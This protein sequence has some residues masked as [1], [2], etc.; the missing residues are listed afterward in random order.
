MIGSTSL[1]DVEYLP[2]DQP[3]DALADVGRLL[4]LVRS[5]VADARFARSAQLTMTEWSAFFAGMVNAYLAADS[6]AGRAGLVAVP[7]ENRAIAE[8]R[9][10]PAARSATG[11]HVKAC[12]R[13]SRA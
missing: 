5:L 2:H 12:A 13:R 11:S 4:V 9:R 1:G 3:A 8:L 7:P 10:Q 6:D